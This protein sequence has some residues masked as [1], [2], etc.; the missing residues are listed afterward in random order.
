[1][2]INGMLMW[3]KYRQAKFE[4]VALGLRCEDQATAVK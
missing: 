3:K 4:S 1:M 2:S